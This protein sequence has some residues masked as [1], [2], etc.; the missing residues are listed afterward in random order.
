MNLC[1]MQGVA[2][3]TDNKE[4]AVFKDWLLRHVLST[5]VGPESSAVYTVMTTAGNQQTGTCCACAKTNPPPPI[6]YDY[7]AFFETTR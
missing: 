4:Q 3:Q 7:A 6:C 2:H 1:V 5:A